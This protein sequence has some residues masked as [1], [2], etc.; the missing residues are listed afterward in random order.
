MGMQ[1]DLADSIPARMV[2]PYGHPRPLV[3]PRLEVDLP[4][5]L[6]EKKVLLLL[7]NSDPSIC[8]YVIEYRLYVNPQCLQLGEDKIATSMAP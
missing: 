4:S 1:A 2:Y 6:D 5:R 3:I 8:A 7:R